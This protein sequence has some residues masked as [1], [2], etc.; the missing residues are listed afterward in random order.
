MRKEVEIE[1]RTF[2]VRTPEGFEGLSIAL[3]VAA[4][5]GA[6]MLGAAAGICLVGGRPDS[7][8]EWDGEQSLARYGRACFGALVDKA[9]GG[10]STKGASKLCNAAFGLLVELIN[11]RTVT[12]AE[13]EEAGAPFGTPEEG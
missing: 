12:N 1:G 6:P 2:A 4:L 7:V 10:L 8:P 11:D 5:R 9:H 13:V 3:E